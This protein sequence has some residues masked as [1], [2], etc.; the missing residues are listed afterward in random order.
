MET[1]RDVAS[2]G[3]GCR[4]NESQLDIGLHSSPTQ[5]DMSW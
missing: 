1:G 2:S 5:Q 4:D 3:P